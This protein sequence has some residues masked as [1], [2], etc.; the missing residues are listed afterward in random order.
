LPVGKVVWQRPPAAT[1]AQDIKQSVEN[2]PHLDR[3]RTSSGFT[4]GI[5]GRSSSNCSKVKLLA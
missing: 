4:G 1:L 3:A 5:K 2:V